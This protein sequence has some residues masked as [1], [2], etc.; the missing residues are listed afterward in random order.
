[1]VNEPAILMA[2]EPTGN[3]DSK[4]GREILDLILELNRERG[5]T[6]IIVTHDPKIAEHTSRIIRLMDGLIV[7]GA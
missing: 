3:L 1:L 4:S 2:D 5:M 7:E 6:V